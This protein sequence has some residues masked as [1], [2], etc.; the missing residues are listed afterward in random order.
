LPDNS[1]DLLITSPPYL[2][3]RDYTDIYRLELWM[4]DLVKSHEDVRSLR[5]KTLI[6]HVQIKH[7]KILAPHVP[8]LN[9]VIGSILENE[10]DFWN[11][12]IVNMINGYF[13]D[14]GYVFMWLS[15][16]MKDGSKGY[17]NVA[18]SSYFNHEIKVDE[19][20]AE[21]IEQNG[22]TVEEIR[23]ARYLNPSAHQT[24][25]QQKLRESVIVFNNS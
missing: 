4:L 17:V 2:N 7:G 22:F 14:L 23:I 13:R 5:E 25:T 15:R 12:E 18:N 11:P 9:R 24:K 16:K 21:I 3:S 20:L 10:A 1:V 19:I 8:E 6:S